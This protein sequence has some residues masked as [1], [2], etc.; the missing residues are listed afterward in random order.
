MPPPTGGVPPAL[1]YAQ[2]REDRAKDMEWCP[3]ER[4]ALAAQPEGRRNPPRYGD[5][6][7]CGWKHALLDEAPREVAE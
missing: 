4:T 1:Q 3:L 2:L 7:T 6:S 5:C